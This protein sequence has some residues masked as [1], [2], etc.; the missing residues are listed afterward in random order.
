ML[1]QIRKKMF[2]QIKKDVAANK[3]DVAPNKKKDVAANKKSLLQI[4]ILLP[5]KKPVVIP[6]VHTG[7][8]SYSFQALV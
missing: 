2:L 1:L 3:K 7:T 8:Q 6:D 5:K 4:K